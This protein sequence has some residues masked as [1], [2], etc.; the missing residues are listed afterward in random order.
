MAKKKVKGT[1]KSTMTQKRK[2]AHKSEAV[3]ALF[4]KLSVII[5]IVLLVLWAM[6]WYVLSDGPAR[7]LLWAHQHTVTFFAKSG[8]VVTNILVEG[9]VNTDPDALLGIINVRKGDPLF[10]FVPREA[11][12]QIKRIG[13]VKSVYVERRLPDT[14][15]ISLTEREPVALWREADVLSL[16]DRDGVVITQS[17]LERYKN[18]L[19]IQGKG[20]PPKAAILLAL[21]KE[22]PELEALTDHAAFIDKRRWDLILKDGARVKLPEENPAQALTHIIQRHKKTQLLTNKS[23]TEIDARYKDRLIVRTHLGKVQ[24]YK[25]GIR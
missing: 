19:M 7:T 5:L 9:R 6:G 8:F 4:K 3:L 23:I 10:S 25:A 16:I 1:R 15:Y 2:N 13:W 18:L 14:I 12:Q 22:A 20:A 17:A 24:D 21:L 11:K